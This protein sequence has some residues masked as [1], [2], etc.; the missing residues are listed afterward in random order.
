MIETPCG[1]QCLKPGTVPLFIEETEKA[2]ETTVNQSSHLS[3]DEEFDN[4]ELEYFRGDIEKAKHCWNI[5]E[6]TIHNN[7]KRLRSMQ[8]TNR[9]L[10]SKLYKLNTIWKQLE[11][12]N[13]D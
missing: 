4:L 10:R 11:K 5:V 3:L 1:Q 9:R 13:G 6:S 2:E 7:K 8:Q 12:Q